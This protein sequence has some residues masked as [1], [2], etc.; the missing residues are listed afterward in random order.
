MNRRTLSTPTVLLL[1]I[2]VLATASTVRAQGTQA[3]D[4]AIHA[5]WADI[6]P[7][8]A[9]QHGVTITDRR[10]ATNPATRRL[11]YGEALRRLSDDPALQRLAAPD[12]SLIEQTTPDDERKYIDLL[13]DAR[14]EHTQPKAVNATSTNTAAG[15]VAERSGFT[16]LLALALDS[17]NFFNADQTAVSL[18]LNALALFSLADP[19]VYSELH[20]YQQHSLV[21]RIGGTIV[22]GAKIP[23]KEITGLSGLPSADTLLDAF[24][25]DVKVRVLG[26]KD[27][28]ARKWYDETLGRA[29]VMNQLIVVQADVPP[30]DLMVVTEE[31]N[32]LVGARLA[33]LKRRINRSAQLTFKTS[34]TH[35][36]KETGKNKYTAGLLFD[37]GV[38]TDTDITANLLYSVTDDVRLGADQLFQVKQLAINAS[39]MARLA[40]DA[41]VTG[42]TV[43]WTNGTNITTYLGT[44]A[45]PF[46]VS[47]TWKLFTKLEIPVTDAATIPLSVVYTNDKNE[48]SKTNYVT[49]FVGIAYD[50]SAVPKLFRGAQ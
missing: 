38:G 3:I 30:E 14:A 25:W 28:R 16:E 8:V 48:L 46:A 44:T 21:R 4:D 50:F 45:L 7:D 47:N 34:G 12:L 6:L 42:R 1:A 49:G 41:I 10:L 43:D 26:D 13:K 2:A 23:E 9:R 19:E 35:L 33:L 5:R 36:T 22:F 24:T 37:Q 18:N 40:R 39:V 17:Q 32:A 27:P 20:R 15:R 31:L 11:I 29:G